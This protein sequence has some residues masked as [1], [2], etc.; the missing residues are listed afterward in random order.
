MTDKF[1]TVIGIGGFG[2]VYHGVN[3]RNRSQVAVKVLSLS[4]SQGQKEFEMEA[5]LHVCYKLFIIWKK[6]KQ[7]DLYIECRQTYWWTSPTRIWWL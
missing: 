4:S 3:H 1:N 7:A 6:E 2:K 5:W